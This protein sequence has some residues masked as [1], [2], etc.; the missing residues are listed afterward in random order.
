MR[1]VAFLVGRDES[2]FLPL[3]LQNLKAQT[4][5]PSQIIFVDDASIDNSA[6]IAEVY[7]ATV[8]KLK[9]RHPSYTGRP[10]L[11][12]IWNQALQSINY[13]LYDYMLQCGADVVLPLNYIEE[14]VKRME[15]DLRLVIASGV[16]H[17][18]YTYRS[19]ARGAGRMYKIWFWN[20]HIKKYPFVYSWESSPLYKA[21]SLGFK[22]Q[23]FPDLEMSALRATREYKIFYGYAMRE[24]GY[25]PPYALGRCLLAIAKNHKIGLKMLYTYLTSPFRPYDKAISNYIKTYQ[26]NMIKKVISNPKILLKR[27]GKT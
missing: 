20:Q 5:R 18:E 26:I 25:L 10:E 3:V 16:V 15:K 24:L 1:V 12:K 19:H 17:G 8:I 9:H 11:A 4:L 6:E 7:G 22:V 27:W 21:L 23:S 13:S 14:L 2:Q